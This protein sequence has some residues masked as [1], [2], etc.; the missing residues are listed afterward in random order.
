MVVQILGWAST[1]RKANQREL[2]GFSNQLIWRY[3]MADKYSLI[4]Q[5]YLNHLFEYKNG[6]L[7]WKN[8]ILRSK[9]KPGD[10]AGTLKKDGRLAIT[11]HSKIFSVHRLIFLMH[12][13]WLPKEIDHIDCN[14]TNN[15]IENLRPATRSENSSNRGLMANNTSGIKGVTWHRT[16]NK[17]EA[18]CQVNKKRVKIGYFEELSEAE[19]V[20]KSFREQH[21]GAYARHQ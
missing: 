12:H 14:P 13:N 11:I 16:S 6:E 4:N 8:P 15:N 7:F 18:S 17:W 3:R 9:M 19:K 2:T 5:N 10:R 21:H 20:V 1:M